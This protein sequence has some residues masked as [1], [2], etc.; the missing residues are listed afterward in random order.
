MLFENEQ[1][2][3]LKP[4]DNTNDVGESAGNE[5]ILSQVL[6][7]LNTTE[8]EEGVTRV[9]NR[10]HLPNALHAV[11]ADGPGGDRVL[12]GEQL[13]NKTF[14]LRGGAT[15]Q[16][17][18]QYA[19]IFIDKN[20]SILSNGGDGKVE[21]NYEDDTDSNQVESFT[22]SIDGLGPHYTL[23]TLKSIN[24]V[25]GTLFDTGGAGAPAAAD[26]LI[27]GPACVDDVHNI[28]ATSGGEDEVPADDPN[29]GSGDGDG[30]YIAAATTTS[31]RVYCGVT[32]VTGLN[33]NVII[34]VQFHF[35]FKNIGTGTGIEGL[36]R[37]GGGGA[38]NVVVSAFTTL[39]TE[40]G[41]YT[42]Q[43]SSALAN[44]PDSGSPW[45]L[46]EIADMQVGVRF[47]GD[48]PT[49]EK[50][51]SFIRVR[52]RYRAGFV[53]PT[54]DG[55]DPSNVADLWKAV[56]KDPFVT[57]TDDDTQ[58]VTFHSNAQNQLL[59][60][61]MEDLETEATTAI[62]VETRVRC[63]Y[64]HV[65]EKNGAGEQDLP[66]GIGTD[67]RS[68]GTERNQLEGPLEQANLGGFKVI[69]DLTSALESARFL[70]GVGNPVVGGC[71]GG[72]NKQ[73]GLDLGY[74]NYA[75]LVFQSTLD[76]GGG[77]IDAADVNAIEAG[78]RVAEQIVPETRIS[79]IYTYCEYFR[80]PTG[81]KFF[82]IVVDDDPAS[83]TD[84]DFMRSQ[85]ST[86]KKMSVD[87][88]GIP[89]V[90]Q[91]NS[92]KVIMRA[93]VDVGA[94]QGWRVI[95]SISGQSDI[96][97]VTETNST[98][99]NKE[100]VLFTNPNT[101]ERFTRTEI[102]TA[103]VAFESI[104]E[105]PYFG[106]EVSI[107]RVEVDFDPIP[108]KIDNARRI[109]SER[110][111]MLSKP[112]GNLA[113][114][115]PMEKANADLMRDVAATHRAIPRSSTGLSLEQWDRSMMRVFSK[116][117][118]LENDRL[119]FDLFP[120][121]D[122]LV[123][124]LFTGQTTKKGRSFDG[125]MIITN[126]VTVQFTRPTNAY[127]EDPFAGRLLELNT[128]EPQAS[129]DGVLVENRRTNHFLNSGFSDGATNVFTE[130]PTFGLPA[131]GA[132]VV[133]DLEDLTWDKNFLGAP[134]RSVK[135]TGADT[136]ATLGIVQTE[137][138]PSGEALSPVGSRYVIQIYH[139]DDSGS[140]ISIGL[141][142]DPPG[143]TEEH[144]TVGDQKWAS[145]A[146]DW[147]T[148]PIRS[149]PTID[150]IPGHLSNMDQISTSG[151]P[152]TLDLQLK[153]SAR[154]ASNQ[155]NHIYGV[156]VEGGT[157]QA[158]EPST[159]PTSLILTRTGP[160]V[161]DIGKLFVP[162]DVANPTY[163]FTR[164]TF[165]C[166]VD[167]SWDSADLPWFGGERY[168]VYSNVLDASNHDRLYYDQDA[169]GWV[170]ERK[171]A[172]V[173]S[174]ATFYMP[175]VSAGVPI[176]LS[177]RWISSLGDQGEVA[178]SIQLFV[179]DVRG[180]D[181]TP[182]STPTMPTTSNFYI[183]SEEGIDGTALDGEIRRMRITQQVL[184]QDKISKL[185]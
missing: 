116:T 152:A 144:F 158:N 47:L 10:G 65:G 140:P 184:T 13:G 61:E 176:R 40:G 60:F 141:S 93:K 36:Y 168:Y 143:F 97:Q 170:F 91:V 87:F 166:I 107:I 3:R 110:L 52:I 71:G 171:V 106:K 94:T 58:H 137:A 75:E 169:E 22:M 74:G 130:W 11:S 147:W 14:Q 20:N 49:I 62:S 55:D 157:F 38:D 102:N 119:G 132:S 175:A 133:E 99:E 121:I 104:G 179:N 44:N 72:S 164:G 29:D 182:A 100:Y 95:V 112:V 17:P 5:G 1:E 118:D 82:H 162:N 76:S 70:I 80:D 6:M 85:H 68:N 88:A 146:Q 123:T 163:Y 174:Q 108:A 37:D 131:A 51:C 39:G 89:E 125:M 77:V 177:T 134:Q 159:Y 161:R 126:G 181:A 138:I 34:S 81:S 63:T 12:L 172:T 129:T 173:T 42:I 43:S 16:V 90:I 151:T 98:F 153:I 185:R 150:R 24:S 145:G 64:F 101:G 25:V 33:I 4:N 109:N 114:E 79:R 7:G 128:D 154:T 8:V 67:P 46:T 57:P 48:D 21:I 160:V 19:I 59:Q 18:T 56:A 35:F 148:L 115:A 124:F 92:L 103:T 96:V 54:I 156:Q 26:Q 9:R 30:S 84:A 165:F 183:G 178:F 122:Y 86:N 66:C 149:T 135:I 73:D 167:T 27:V 155:V 2:V 180:V 32:E 50:R 83:P 41:S 28:L 111:L 15:P 117:Y 31:E 23:Q 142:I 78:V 69:H 127:M 139:K 53:H 105:T 136:P 45:T 120:M 113:W